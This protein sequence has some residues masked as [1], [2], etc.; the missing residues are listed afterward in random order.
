MAAGVVV[1]FWLERPPEEAL[2]VATLAEELG[3]PELWIGEMLHFD[4]FA[5]AGAVAALTKRITITV[6]PL[7]I[8]LRDPVLLAMGIASIAVLGSRGARLALGASTPAVVEQWHGR[9]WGG[10]ADRIE[11]AVTLI[12]AVLSGSRTAHT[13]PHFSSRG[14]R[15]A[16][17]ANAAHISVAGLNPRMLA[18]AGR[19]ADR[20][21]LNLVPPELV[22]QTVERV[23]RPTAVW[24]AAA[25]E[26]AQEGWRQLSRQ[27][28]MYLGAPGY[29][30]VLRAT[31]LGEL[32]DAAIRG[33]SVAELAD[34]ITPAHLETITAVGDV[35]QVRNAI[36]AYEPS[37][38]E[39]MVV[40]VT[41]GDRDGR[42]TL[43]AL[44]PTDP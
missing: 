24:V 29:R 15:S 17:G 41:A 16:L 7:A 43:E 12:R 38:A 31:G 14:F 9:A 6:G 22:A 33:T 2:Q 11:D 20:V 35:D 3:Y 19:A 36:S 10:E 26:P 1:P 28:A 27:V 40:P 18:A 44:A 25:V 21:V 39:V 8:G 32:V 23:Q 34:G 30:D 37:G 5:L 4:A 13:G 42:R